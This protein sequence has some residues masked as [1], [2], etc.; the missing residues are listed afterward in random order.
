MVVVVWELEIWSII[1]ARIFAIFRL[2]QL[3]LFSTLHRRTRG[4]GLEHQVGRLLIWGQ[5]TNASCFCVNS[6]EPFISSS[7][8]LRFSN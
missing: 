3:P 1:R 4:R 7:L 5:A 6:L 8:C 2:H